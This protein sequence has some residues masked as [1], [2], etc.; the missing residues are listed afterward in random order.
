MSV[1]THTALETNAK[2]QERYP[3]AAPLRDWTLIDRKDG[4]G[5]QIEFWNAA[6]LGRKPTIEELFA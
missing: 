1:N 6:K 2:I 4:Q 3:D 5:P